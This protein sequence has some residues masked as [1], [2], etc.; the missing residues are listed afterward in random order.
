MDIDESKVIAVGSAAWLIALVVCL[1]CYGKLEEHD[2]EWWV[3]VCAGGLGL[4]LWGWLL[5]RKR[6]AARR[7]GAEVRP[8]D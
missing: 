1:A 5:T 4:G 3:W 6:I 8:T 7:S 2:R